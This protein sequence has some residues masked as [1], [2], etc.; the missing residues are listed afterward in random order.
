MQDLYKIGQVL[1][2]IS[3]KA[4]TVV[5]VQIQEINRKT[6]I[7]GEETHFLVMDPEGRGPYNLEEING[8][9]F[10]NSADVARALKDNANKAIDMMVENALEIASEKFGSA[11]VSNDLFQQPKKSIEKKIVPPLAPIKS[12]QP[13]KIN[14]PA[15]KDGI[16][17]VEVIGK[18]GKAHMQKQKVRIHMPNEI[19]SV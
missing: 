6:T 15:S 16:S 3:S 4:H 1:Y 10:T 13:P 19:A 8:Q 5:P 14:P 12:A 11:D 2:I 17:E 7:E 9:I 18:D